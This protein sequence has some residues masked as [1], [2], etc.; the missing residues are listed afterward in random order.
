MNNQIIIGT[1]GNQPFAIPDHKVSR[2]HALLNINPNGQY[3]LIDN[4]STNGTFIYNGQNFV[5]LYP[6]QPYPVSPD[7]MIQLGPETRFHIRRLLTKPNPGPQGA[8]GG[9]QGAAGGQGGQKPKQPKKVDISHL[10]HISENYDE[11]KIRLESKSGMINGLRGCTVLIT[12]LA[13]TAGTFLTGENG[14]KV[15][16]G[17]ICMGVA[18]VLM[19]LLLVFIN[20]YNKKIMKMKK[21]N[22]QNYAVKY[23]CPECHVSFRGKIYENILAERNCPRC[24]SIYYD[25]TVNA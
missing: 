22:E 5:R 20:S 2:R 21:D 23:V 15:T 17:I 7:T 18:L 16:S 11:Q 6:N 4:G 12:M 3:F 13:G 25:K 14:D 8:Q 24:K 1:Q 10:R 9:Q 19:A